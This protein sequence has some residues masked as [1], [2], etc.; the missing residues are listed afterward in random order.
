[1]AYAFVEKRSKDRELRAENMTEF[2]RFIGL[3]EC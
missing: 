3:G 1:M 2:L